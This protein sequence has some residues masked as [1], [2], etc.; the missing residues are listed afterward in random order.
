MAPKAPLATQTAAD[1]NVAPGAAPKAASKQT[2]EQQYQKLSHREHILQRPDT[3]VGSVEYHT[4]DM[5]VMDAETNRMK[6]RKLTFVPGLYKIYDEIL[7]NAA[8]NKQ[9]DE[10]MTRM[11]I[12]I[13]REAGRI[14]VQNNGKGIPVQIH[15]EHGIYVP[16]LIFGTLR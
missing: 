15:K 9:R 2:V 3:Y 16:E 7:V 4:Q 13:D 14:S 8:D 1:F 11:D 10:S 6:N 5:W 12:D